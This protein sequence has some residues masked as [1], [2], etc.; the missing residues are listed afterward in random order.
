MASKPEAF[1]TSGIK[2]RRCWRAVSQGVACVL[3]WWCPVYRWREFVVG[4]GMEQENLSSRYRR[5]CDAQDGVDLVA[6]GRVASGDNRK[7][8]STDAGHRGGPARSSGE[9]AVMVLERRGRTGQ[10]TV[11]P[12]LR[13]R[14]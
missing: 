14:S 4:A 9:G 12:T 11:R 5:P 10:V 7:P 2:A 6:R 1:G 3:P 13:G 8:Q